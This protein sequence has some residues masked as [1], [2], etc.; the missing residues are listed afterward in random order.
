MLHS[1]HHQALMSTLST[2]KNLFQCKQSK[3]F[4]QIN[5]NDYLYDTKNIPIKGLFKFYD[6]FLIPPCDNFRWWRH[7]QKSL[8]L[9]QMVWAIFK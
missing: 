5:Y 8:I 1:L 7:Q 3:H 4:H 9:I 6:Q 2:P